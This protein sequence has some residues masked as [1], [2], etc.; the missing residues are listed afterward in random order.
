MNVT[1]QRSFQ[2]KG[3]GRWTER[4]GHFSPHL[5]LR[6]WDEVLGR[7]V[8][9]R[10]KGKQ[11]MSL[12]S[13]FPREKSTKGSGRPRLSTPDVSCDDPVL[14]EIPPGHR[15][16]IMTG[17][18]RSDRRL[19]TQRVVVSIKRR[20]GPYTV[21]ELRFVNPTFSPGSRN[22]GFLLFVSSGHT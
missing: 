13:L 4:K 16:R 7:R 2:R 21:V 19:S 3:I 20:Q 22:S 12:R 15:V 17:R 10:V 5:D 1:K 18:P 9:F 6:I 11:S 14:E 8:V